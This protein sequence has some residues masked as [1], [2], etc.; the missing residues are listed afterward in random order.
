LDRR[1]FFSGRRSPT[2]ELANF[3]EANVAAGRYTSSGEVV[4]E[5]LR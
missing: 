4:R 5:A 1:R 2:D 3:A